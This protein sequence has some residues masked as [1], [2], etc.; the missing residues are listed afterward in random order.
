MIDDDLLEFEDELDTVTNETDTDFWHILVVDDDPEV[1]AVTDL[2]LKGFTFEGKRLKIDN[3]PSAEEAK[4]MLSG[5]KYKYAIAILDVVMESDHAGLHLVKWIREELDDPY[6]RIV[7]RTGQPGQAPEREVISTFD[8][9]D[10]KE[11]TELTSQKLYTLICASLRAYRDMI[12]L[13]ENK[14]GLETIIRSTAELFA[15][16]SLDEFTQGAL[17]QIAAL[18]HLNEGAVYSELNTLAATRSGEQSTVIAAT[19]RFKNSIRK[20]LEQTL[21]TE[22]MQRVNEVIKNGGQE[23]GD[24]HFVGVYGSKVG[25]THVLLLEGLTNLSDLDRQLIKIFGQNLGVAFDNQCMSEEVE[26]TQREIV[27]RMSEA[28]ENRSKETGNHVKRM[29]LTCKVL[30]E[31]HGL[32]SHDLDVLYK[33]A[34]L[35][36]IGKI[37][38]PDHILN[39]PGKLDAHEW[40]V[41]QTHAQIGHDI[42]AGSELEILHAG[43]IISVGHHENWDGSGYP[44]GVQGEDIHIFARIAAVADVFDALVNKRAYKDAWDMKEVEDFFKEMRGVKFQ[45]ELV[46]LMFENLDKLIE[47]QKQFPD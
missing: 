7:L 19:G 40:Q 32:N 1:H 33:A 16:K 25:R 39:K 27:Y 35:H 4:T 15:H 38:I 45:P 10:Y 2:A 44:K 20:S 17:Q 37:A 31:A 12:A 29:A 13:Y 41:M 47:I 14:V 5:Q 36:D 42:L 8:I 6:V 26:L 3:A 46:D 43:A 9:N 23:F 18:L 34:P 22:E 11:K 30:G 28:V 24:T 21:D